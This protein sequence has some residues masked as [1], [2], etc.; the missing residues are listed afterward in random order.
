MSNFAKGMRHG[1]F[2]T[3]LQ[4]KRVDGS[5]KTIHNVYEPYLDLS[6]LAHQTRKPTLRKAKNPT[7]VVEASRLIICDGAKDERDVSL[8]KVLNSYLQD[9]LQNSYCSL[10]EELYS[11]VLVSTDLEENDRYHLLKLQT[12]MMRVCRLQ[13]YQQKPFKINIS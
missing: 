11:Q 13:A 6:S 8:V 7:H 3:S 12:F 5:S 2:G 4:V 10:I 1:K 9:M